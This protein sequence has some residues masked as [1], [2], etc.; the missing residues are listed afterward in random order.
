MPAS[1]GNA[2]Q[3]TLNGGVAPKESMDGQWVYYWKK[4]GLWKTPS[5]GGEELR[6]LEQVGYQLNFVVA[7]KG[8]YFLNQ[9][10]EKTK[11]TLFFFSFASRELT[12]LR[13]IYRTAAPWPLGLA[14]SPDQR[15]LLFHLWDRFDGDLMLVENFR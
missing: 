1:G 5:S 10:K 6:E 8:I 7:D 13:E 2:T 11:V 4:Q 9:V 14:I 12:P 3:L 15:W